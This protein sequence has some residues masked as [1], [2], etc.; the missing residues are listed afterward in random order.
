M[1]TGTRL[2]PENKSFGMF[3]NYFAGRGNGVGKREA[4]SKLHGF[5][6]QRGKEFWG[7]REVKGS[8]E[9]LWASIQFT[10]NSRQVYHVY[11]FR[12]NSRTKR[13]PGNSKEKLKRDCKLKQV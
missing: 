12:K 10:L 7:G 11:L 9:V 3:K 13:T 2:Q 8:P 1:G 4:I 5:S 6:S